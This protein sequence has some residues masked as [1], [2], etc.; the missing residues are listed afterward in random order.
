MQ[1]EDEQQHTSL[2]WSDATPGIV[3]M[4]HVRPGQV[5]V[6]G[7]VLFTVDVSPEAQ[8]VAPSSNVFAKTKKVWLKYFVNY[9]INNF[10]CR[11]AIIT[12]N[13]RLLSA[14]TSALASQ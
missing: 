5:V 10:L 13:Y 4:V 14:T 12:C 9:K 6:P 8:Q 2:S 1:E 7:D 3:A 11:K